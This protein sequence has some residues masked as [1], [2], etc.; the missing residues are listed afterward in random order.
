MTPDVLIKKLLAQREFWVVLPDGK[1]IKLRRPAERQIVDLAKRGDDGEAR[2]EFGVETIKQCA[3]DWDGIAEADLLPGGASDAV[4]FDA[5]LFAL[6]VDDRRDWWQPLSEALMD[7][8][9]RHL[10][11]AETARGN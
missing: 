8:I 10:G 9:V 6:L 4:P 1:R 11:A 5:G 7:H 2:I 3:V